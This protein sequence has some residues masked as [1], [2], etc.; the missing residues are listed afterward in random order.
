V[1]G[2]CPLSISDK[3]DLEVVPEGKNDESTIARYPSLIV[4]ASVKA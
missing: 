4:K 1:Q 3:N 2:I